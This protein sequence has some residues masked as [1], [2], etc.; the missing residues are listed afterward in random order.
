MAMFR[1]CPAPEISADK[2]K[3]DKPKPHKEDKEKPKH[4]R[5]DST[6]SKTEE[7]GKL[8]DFSEPYKENAD[9]K[10]KSSKSATSYDNNDYDDDDGGG[11]WDEFWADLFSDV[12]SALILGDFGY[13]YSSCPYNQ[14]QQ[15]LPGIY[16]ST[17]ND[18][19]GDMTAFQFRTYY[20]KVDTDIQGYGLYGKLLFPSSWTWDMENNHYSENVNNQTDSMDYFTTHFNTIGL[21]PDTN[22]VTEIGLGMAFLTDVTDEVHSSGSFQIRA[23]YFPAEP[24]S[25]R[26]SAS[27]AS[28]SDVKTTNFDT[29]VG[30]HT[31][32]LEIFGGYHSLINNKSI[33]LNGPTF[34][35]A[36][37]F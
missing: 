17:N 37:W 3:P 15:P 36:L 22:F 21:T 10:N 28:P 18:T 12:F 16:V 24:W 35:L 14:P 6:P 27:F 33:N 19:L 20:N 2:N 7:K 5:D 8:G 25:I 1:I 13:R 31:G 26:A 32:S 11:F 4:D 23:D 29:T 9:K 34:G 30:W